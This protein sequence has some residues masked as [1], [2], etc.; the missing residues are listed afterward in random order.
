M[1][2]YTLLDLEEASEAQSDVVDRLLQL[3]QYDFS[4][5]EG[6]AIDVTGR[7][8]F[9]GPW[10]HWKEPDHYAFLVRVDGELAGVVL[11]KPTPDDW[12]DEPSRLVHEFFVMRKF[13]RRGVGR[14]V[15]RRLFDRLPGRWTL[16]QSLHNEGAKQF[17]RT[18]LTEYTGHRYDDV[19]VNGRPT[20]RF[21]SAR[22]A[23]KTT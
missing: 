13:R 2:G 14:E 5:I 3:Y 11:V 15:A 21:D 8:P 22:A 17:W 20:Q 6:G 7:Y 4:E 23:E 16:Q 10:T 12:S 1:S 18:V 9:I 19:V